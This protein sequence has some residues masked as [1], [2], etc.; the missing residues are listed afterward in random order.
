MMICASLSVGNCSAHGLRKAA[1]TRL[2]EIGCTDYE[3]MSITGHRI[4]KKLQ[5]YTEAARQKVLADNAISK[6][7]KDIDGT[8]VS[9]LS[10]SH[11]LV[12]QSDGKSE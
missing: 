12:R 4:L 10:D 6:V 7:Q 11:L 8:K 3:I 2:A 9:Y 1:A 5:K